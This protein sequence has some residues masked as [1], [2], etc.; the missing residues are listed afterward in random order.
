MIYMIIVTNFE[1]KLFTEVV[2][3]VLTSVYIFF[4][5]FLY[6]YIEGFNWKKMCKMF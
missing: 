4:L 2:K 6:F 1:V 3:V 5:Y